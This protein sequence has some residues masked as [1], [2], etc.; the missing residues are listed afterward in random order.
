MQPY[1]KRRVESLNTSIKR[2]KEP[3]IKPVVCEHIWE[4]DEIDFMSGWTEKSMSITY[5]ILCYKTKK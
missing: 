5:C 3:A 4:E 2:L 1:K